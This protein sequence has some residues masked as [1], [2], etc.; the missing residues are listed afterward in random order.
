[1]IDYTVDADGKTCFVMSGLT[2]SLACTASGTEVSITGFDEIAAGTSISVVAYLEIG[3]TDI[4]TISIT[5]K[6]DSSI[7]ID[8]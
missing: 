5:T 8:Q 6:D 2:G 7:I 4:S 1:M 3:S